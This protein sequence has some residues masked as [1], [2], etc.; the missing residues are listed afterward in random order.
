VLIQE[1]IKGLTEV[2]SLASLPRDPAERQAVLDK[3]DLVDLEAWSMM[4]G[5]K[6]WDSFI[7]AVDAQNDRELAMHL[8]RHVQTMDVDEFNEFM[9]AV[10]AKSPQGIQM[11]RELAA[12]IKAE[13]G[14]QEG[15]QT[16]TESIIEHLLESDDDEEADTWKDTVGHSPELIRQALELLNGLYGRGQIE[17]VDY[18]RGVVHIRKQYGAE[19]AHFR[20]EEN[21]L[22]FRNHRLKLTPEA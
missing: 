17:S 21:I 11:L 15:P 2:A 4:L 5:P 9:K 1:I 18:D 13:L 10:L 20:I 6:L 7:E 16:A 3:T 22:Y 14:D 12:K 8:Y 19:K